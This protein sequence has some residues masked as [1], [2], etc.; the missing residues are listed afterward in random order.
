MTT[1]IY[2]L[3]GIATIPFLVI[4]VIIRLLRGKETLNSIVERFAI[5]SKK[6]PSS[7]H[8]IWIH[9]ASIGE[10]N[11]AFI[12]I[13]A[14]R[15]HSNIHFLITTQTKSAAKVFINKKTDRCIHHF[16]P[17]D[18]S[19]IADHFVKKW[20]PDLVIFMESEIW[21][22]Y[23]SIIKSPIMLV[24]ARMSEQSFR[25]WKKLGKFASIYFKKFHKIFAAT[26]IDYEHFSY[27]ADNVVKVGN[28]KLAGNKLY[29]N[30]KEFAALKKH[31]PAHK[32]IVFASISEDEIKGIVQV[33][34]K[35]CTQYKC[36]I[37]PRHISAIP[38]VQNALKQRGIRSYLRSKQEIE[39]KGIYLVD[40]YNELGLFYAL[41]TVV[42][43]GGSLCKKRGGQNMV[44][45]VRFN[46]PTI[47]GNNT[48]N[49]TGIM[50]ELKSAK[51]ILEVQSFDELFENIKE[52][53][54]DEKYYAKQMSNVE[55]FNEKYSN[56][57]DKYITSV[58]E[59]LGSKQKKIK[60][61]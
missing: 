13:D 28:I 2:R 35:L 18:I 5:S 27:F 4:Y 49:F 38:K 44:E 16:L 33:A 55:H 51:A 24:N 61:S 47:V 37:I 23:L 59:M 57:L 30:K 39:D 46:I 22:L 21:P 58:Q 56:I 48:K 36:I 1:F 11:A 17:F 3:L 9:A 53:L 45:A 32:V 31:F 12:L 50:N 25:K 40:S 43:V 26:P 34:S 8:F 19:I 15:E 29:Y 52:L 10:M 6:R 42:F 14:L 20:S 7:K 54:V 41:A 60:S